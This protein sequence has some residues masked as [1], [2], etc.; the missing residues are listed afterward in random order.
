MWHGQKNKY[1]KKKKKK[2]SEW[3]CFL[4]TKPLWYSQM[5]RQLLHNCLCCHL[6]FSGNETEGQRGQA[7]FLKLPSRKGCTVPREFDAHH[8]CYAISPHHYFFLPEFFPPKCPWVP[9]H[10][11]CQRWL[12]G[13]GPAPPTC[14]PLM[15]SLATW[16]WDHRGRWNWLC[17]KNLP[18][19]TRGSQVWLT[20]QEPL[21]VV[22]SQLR[23]RSCVE[24]S[25]SGLW[26]AGLEL[27]A[28]LPLCPLSLNL[29]LT[30]GA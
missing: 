21:R 18:P 10:L 30:S 12:W 13:S 11:F 4:C 28:P 27:N 24:L 2:K 6:H 3:N 25:G 17:G 19:F 26:G 9:C 1:L 29:Q 23:S 22:L 16:G 5:P 14:S 15:R 8:P 7:A 20:G